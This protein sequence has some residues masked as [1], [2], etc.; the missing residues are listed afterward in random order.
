MTQID[1]TRLAEAIRIDCEERGH[2]KCGY[3]KCLCPRTP[4]RV[5]TVI[6][7]WEA[8][9]SGPEAKRSELDAQIDAEIGAASGLGKST[10]IN[11]SLSIPMPQ[12]AATPRPRSGMTKAE[13][14]GL[15][16]LLDYHN[17]HAAAYRLAA[18]IRK[19]MEHE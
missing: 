9:A 7:A 16:W 1:E 10:L 18:V 5:R 19:E 4:N 15:L 8:S 12:G 11:L 13:R 17:G 2:P 3:P 6:A 14:E